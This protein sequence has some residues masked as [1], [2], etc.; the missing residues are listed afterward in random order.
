MET[1]KSIAKPFDMGYV[2]RI[3]LKHM[4]K[5]VD[6]SIRKT[7]DR[8]QDFD[9]DSGEHEKSKEVFMTLSVLHQLRKMLDDFQEHNKELFKN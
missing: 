1:I 9:G 3:T 7:F 8:V 5:S 6:I 4:R 2:L